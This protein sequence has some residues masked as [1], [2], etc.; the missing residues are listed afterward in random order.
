MPLL[1]GAQMDKL[2]KALPEKWSP[3]FG[4]EVRK[5]KT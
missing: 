2:P 5:I 3:V 4:Q 1:N